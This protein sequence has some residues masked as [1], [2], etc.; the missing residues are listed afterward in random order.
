M[1]FRTASPVNAAPPPGDSPIVMPVD[2]RLASKYHPN[3][4]AVCHSPV[5]QAT[6][7]R[8]QSE[9]KVKQDS[10]ERSKT[11]LKKLRRKSQGK[12][13]SKYECRENEVRSE[14]KLDQLSWR[15]EMYPRWIKSVL[16]SWWRLFQMLLHLQVSFISL[17]DPL[18]RG[19]LWGSQ[20][21][22]LK[23][24]QAYKHDC[25]HDKYVVI[26]CDYSYSS[27]P[28]VVLQLQYHFYN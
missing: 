13:S 27:N 17:C 2:V 16:I 6:F 24:L 19:M 7:K 12:N 28:T 5:K 21:W 22:L 11:D 14:I 23:F 15:K 4:P 18:F 3:K 9:H 26:E 20:A 8:Y 25:Y 10:L 1:W